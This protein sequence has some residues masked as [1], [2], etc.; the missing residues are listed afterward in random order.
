MNHLPASVRELIE[1]VGVG[2][3][4]ALVRAFAGNVIK[5]PSRDRRA[6]GMRARLIEIMGEAAA[7]KLIDHYSGETLTIA[8]C[9][10]ALRAERDRK[11]VADYDAGWPVAALASRERM[12]ERQI[13]TILARSPGEAGDANF[14]AQLVQFRLF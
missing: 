14:V 3:A 11:I 2:P 6:G 13:R 5:V 4:L 8:R 10:A 12:T 7:L 1:L 9:V